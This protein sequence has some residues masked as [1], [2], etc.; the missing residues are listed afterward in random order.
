M[1]RTAKASTKKTTSKK[2]APSKLLKSLPESVEHLEIVQ[3]VAGILEDMQT[4]VVDVKAEAS[5]ELKKLM[6]LYEGNYK[7]LEKKVHVVTKE[8]K[9]QAQSSLIH[10]LQKWHE[11]KEKLPAPLTKEIEKIIEQIGTKA[12][13]RKHHDAEQEAVPKKVR[14]PRT[15]KTNKTTKATKTVKAPK[16]SKPTVPAKKTRVNSKTRATSAPIHSQV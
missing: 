13:A 8:A 4:R 2:R 3:Q 11:H 9:K 16:A 1:A 12:A 10:L 14:T 6:K 15:S 5:K 7:A